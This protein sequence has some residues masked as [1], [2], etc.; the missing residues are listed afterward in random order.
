MIMKLWLMCMILVEIILLVCMFWWVSD[1]L[2][3]VVKD[4]VFG[5]EVCRLDIKI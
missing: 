3:R 4:L 5:L 1:F 2:N